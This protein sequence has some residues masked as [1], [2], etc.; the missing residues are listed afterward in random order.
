MGKFGLGSARS[1][2]DYEIFSGF[3]FKNTRIQD[4][5]LQV[6]EPPNPLDYENQFIS[7]EYKL[8]CSW[9][10]EHFLSEKN[11]SEVGNEL[12]LYLNIPQNSKCFFDFVYRNV[13]IS[14][15]NEEKIITFAAQFDEKLENNQIKFEAKIVQV[16]DLDTVKGHVEYDAQCMVFSSES[17]NFPQINHKANFYLN[18]LLKF[19]NGLQFL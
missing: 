8:D 1:L 17:G 13:K 19:N 11:N 9:D 15:N 3:D 7:K 2:R 10:I 5:T 16:E 4:Y 6:K 18:K 14:N 12:E